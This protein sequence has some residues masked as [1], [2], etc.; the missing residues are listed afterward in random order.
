VQLVSLLIVPLLPL[1]LTIVPLK[2]IVDWLLK[3]AF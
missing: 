3:L 2:Q 1:T